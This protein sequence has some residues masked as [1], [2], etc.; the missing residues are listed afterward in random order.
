VIGFVVSHFV[1]PLVVTTL[2][3]LGVGT[4]ALFVGR[5]ADGR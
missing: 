5:V 1:V 3:V 2:V 4:L